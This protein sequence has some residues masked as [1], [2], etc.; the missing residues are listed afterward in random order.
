MTD[1]QLVKFAASFRHGMIGRRSSYRMY[2]AVSAPLQG[3][4][5]CHGLETELIEIVLGEINHVWLRLPD[6]RAL[7][8]T[9]DQFRPLF[10]DLDLPPVYLGAPIPHIHVMP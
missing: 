8:P 5:S 4:L 9:A 10:P 7:D 6:G 1:A 2:F 3:L